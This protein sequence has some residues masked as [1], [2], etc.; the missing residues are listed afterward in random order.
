MSEKVKTSLFINRALWEESKLR[1]GSRV[2]LR[3]LSRA[4]ARAEP[5]KN[6]GITDH[7]IQKYLRTPTINI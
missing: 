4:V 6:G 1:V 3:A 5:M 2:G 7:T